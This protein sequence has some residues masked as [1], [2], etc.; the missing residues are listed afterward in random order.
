M[1]LPSFPVTKSLPVI[2]SC[3]AKLQPSRYRHRKVKSLD[4]MVKVAG[5]EPEQGSF[6]ST[7]SCAV[8]CLLP[9]CL[10][11]LLATV[12]F[13]GAVRGQYSRS[14]VSGN[15]NEAGKEKGMFHQLKENFNRCA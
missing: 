6:P 13:H 2:E 3:H 15:P 1:V 9:A 14:P 12:G 8:P 4:H 11:L 5:L 7:V 10:M